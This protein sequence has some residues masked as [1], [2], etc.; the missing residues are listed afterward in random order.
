MTEKPGKR[1]IDSRSAAPLR[2]FYPVCRYAL[3]L[4]SIDLG[5]QDQEKVAAPRGQEPDFT[6]DELLAFANRDVGGDVA[7]EVFRG[8]GYQAGGSRA[9]ESRGHFEGESEIAET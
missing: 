6:E 3:R 8:R 4:G 9:D 7:L 1:G 2:L 5:C